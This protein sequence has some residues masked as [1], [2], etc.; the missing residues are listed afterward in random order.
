VLPGKYKMDLLS[1]IVQKSTRKIFFIFS[2][3]FIA[4]SLTNELNAQDKDST[5]IAT[6]TRPIVQKSRKFL[7]LPAVVKS[8]ET[9]FGFGTA[10]SFFFKMKKN[11]TLLRTSNVEALGLYTLRKQVV[12]VL[13]FNIYFPKEKYILRWR[14]TFSH[15]P[16]KFWGL[17]NYTQNSARESYVYSQVFMNPQL[18]RRVYKKFFVGLTYEFQNVFKLDYPANGL[19]DTENIT[20]RH[21]GKVSGAGI[22]IAWDT[23]NNSFNSTKGFFAQIMALDFSK[24][25]G[26]QFNY[27]NFVIDIRKYIKVRKNDV[28]AFQ[29]FSY[30]NSGNVAYRNMA[31]LGGSDIMRGYYAGRYRDKNSTA[32]QMEYRMN[33]YKRFGIVGFGGFG[34]VSDDLKD[35]TISG[36]KYTWGGGLR[37]AINRKERVNL[38]L[39]YGFGRK[40]NGLYFMVTEAF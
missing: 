38:R 18:L 12:A 1:R 34:E 25:I 10:G 24:T 39:D 13:G 19:F 30:L 15:F 6:S 16:D 8:I 33:V 23:R 35:F 31:T 26:S 36:F 5:V 14:N 27:R 32:F 22:I 2:I 9:S 3:L 40:S 11:D 37:F 7:I 28:L 20:G 4:F 21:G 17:G 29:S